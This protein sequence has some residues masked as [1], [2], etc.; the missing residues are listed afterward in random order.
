MS[1]L[2]SFL[3]QQQPLTE[4]TVTWHRDHMQFRLT[5]YLSRKLPPLDYITSV[6]GV[7]FQ[8]DQRDQGDQVLVVRDPERVHILPGGRLE[9]GESFLQTLEREVLEE[10]GWT[11]HTISLLGFKHFQHLNP[12]PDNYPYPYPDFL[13]AI[14]TAQ[15]GTYIPGA[16]RTDDYELDAFLYPIADITQL[17]LPPGEIAYLAAAQ[18]AHH[19]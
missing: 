17:D 11:I 2:A 5:N 14:Y 9:K 3:A 12:Q 4:E 10:T 1:D 18:A 15:T 13:Q 8:R 19:T 6:R 7:I 16:R